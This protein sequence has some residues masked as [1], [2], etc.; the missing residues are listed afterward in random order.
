MLENITDMQRFIQLNND[1]EGVG[2]AVHG[3]RVIFQRQKT[4]TKEI[5][6][7]KMVSLCLDYATELNRIV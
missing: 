4:E 2:W 5:P 7:S 6:S 3:D 1:K